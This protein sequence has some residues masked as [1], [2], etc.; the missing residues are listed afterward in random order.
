[1]I[2]Q[3][4]SVTN[5]P[6]DPI[7]EDRNPTY[8]IETQYKYPVNKNIVLTPGFYVVLNPQ[9]NSNNSAIWVGVLR[10]SFLF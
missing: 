8:L 3:A 4:A 2:P 10:T 7:N 6:G 5:R 1:L 9:G